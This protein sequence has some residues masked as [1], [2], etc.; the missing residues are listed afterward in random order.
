MVRFN[1]E[2]LVMRNGISCSLHYIDVF[3]TND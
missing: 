1:I 3:T 2:R